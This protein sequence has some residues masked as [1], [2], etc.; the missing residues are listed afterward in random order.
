[1]THWTIWCQASISSW[2]WC[3]ARRC[4]HVSSLGWCFLRI[5]HSLFISFVIVG[6]LST[7]WYS[8]VYYCFARSRTLLS[9][10]PLLFPKPYPTSQKTTL[11]LEFPHNLFIT[12][13]HL[14]RI[15]PSKPHLR[16]TRNLRT[17]RLYSSKFIFNI[18][19]S[20]I[21]ILIHNCKDNKNL[22]LSP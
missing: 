5:G 6:S 18:P 16:S 8:L 17:P 14:P 2:V 13:I 22:P 7:L 3:S 9:P 10:L 15:I 12:P 20:H 4:G 1:M 21:N 11:V 19:F